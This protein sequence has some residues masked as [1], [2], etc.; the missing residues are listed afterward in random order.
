MSHILNSN[1]TQCFIHCKHTFR[2]KLKNIWIISRKI[3]P[4]VHRALYFHTEWWLMDYY[5]DGICSPAVRTRI[6]KGNLAW[7]QCNS[8]QMLFSRAF[9]SIFPH[10]FL[11]PKQQHFHVIINHHNQSH[12]QQPKNLFTCICCLG[13]PPS[14]VRQQQRTFPRKNNTAHES[15]NIRCISNN[16]IRIKQVSYRVA[17]DGKEIS[18]AC[19]LLELLLFD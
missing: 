14:N 2:E 11:L 19:S 8:F 16:V 12:I 4:S 1:V 5:R 3:I 7:L 15:S 9:P 10:R 17:T 6:F 18:I 13:F